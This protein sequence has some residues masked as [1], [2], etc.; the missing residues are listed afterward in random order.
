MKATKAASEAE[1]TELQFLANAKRI[2]L[3]VFDRTANFVKSKCRL[4]T[5][6]TPAWIRE[7]WR[8]DTAGCAGRGECECSIKS[9]VMN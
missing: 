7:I 6:S 4:R 1:Q 5:R 9:F 3:K 2:S 8:T